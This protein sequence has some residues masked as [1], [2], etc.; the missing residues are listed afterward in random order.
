MPAREENA[1]FNVPNNI[2]LG[3]L[4][5]IDNSKVDQSSQKNYNAQNVLSSARN[6]KSQQQRKIEAIEA[7]RD[8]QNRVITNLDS[9]KGKLENDI[10][11]I[12]RQ[13]QEVEDAVNDS[14]AL[15]PV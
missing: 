4:D 10:V 1:V 2:I 7:Q 8:T 3:A 15:L 9:Q 6:E 13:I 12:T 11:R 14:P 5:R